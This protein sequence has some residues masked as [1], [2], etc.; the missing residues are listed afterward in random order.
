M[1]LPDTQILGI[2]IDAEPERVRA[3]VV[4]YAKDVT[5]LLETPFDESKVEVV[6]GHAGP[7]YGV[8]HEATI[9]AIKLAGRLEALPLNPVYLGKGL[10]GPALFAYARL[11]AQASGR[12][13]TKPAC[14]QGADR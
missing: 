11:E 2:D 6:G 1:A 14:N 10:G 8:P 3:D 5:G 7:A 13:E 9:E 4:T 12:A